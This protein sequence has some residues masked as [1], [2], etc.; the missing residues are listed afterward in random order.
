MRILIAPTAYKGTL[1]P[2]QA[3]RAIAV[4]IHRAYPDAILDRCPIADGGTG[5]LEVWQFHLG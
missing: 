2:L 3:C 4:G 5:W 1:S